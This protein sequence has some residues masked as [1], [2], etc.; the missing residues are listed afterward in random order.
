MRSSLPFPMACITNMPLKQ[1]RL[2]KH[3]LTEKPLDITIEAMDAMIDA[4]KNNNVKLGVCYQYRSNPDIMILREML[5]QGIL[6]KPVAADYRINCWR[7]QSYYDSASY[8]GGY[9]IDGGGPFIQQA[10]H[11]ID[12]Y[13]WFFG[14]P[15]KNREYARQ[16]PS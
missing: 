4:C 13:A 3:V 16:I 8:R 12:L 7:E 9:E 14:K 5:S 10:C 6:G 2:G 1:P 15:K 11:Q